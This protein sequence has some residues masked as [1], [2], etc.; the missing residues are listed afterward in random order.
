VLTNPGLSAKKTKPSGLYCTAYLATTIFT[1][2]LETAYGT[3]P[4]DSDTRMKSVSPTPEEMTMTFLI[5][6][7]ESSGKKLLIVWITPRTLIS[8]CKESGGYKYETTIT[9]NGGDLRDNE[10]PVPEPFHLY[11]LREH[12]M[13]EGATSS[14]HGLTH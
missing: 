10:S 5:E 1:A 8:N 12:N 14:K 3:Q 11:Y 13:S 6:L 9:E 2:A 7:L 4:E